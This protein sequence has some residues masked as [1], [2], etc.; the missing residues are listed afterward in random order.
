ML[1]QL[2]GAVAAA[3]AA[4]VAEWV[5]GMKAVGVQRVVSMLSES[6]L[7]TYAEPLPAAM[8]AAFGAGK[9]INVDAKAPGASAAGVCS[10]FS[11]C[12]QGRAS[13]TA[14]R[15]C[16]GAKPG[17]KTKRYQQLVVSVSCQTCPAWLLVVSR[18][19]A[20]GSAGTIALA[21]LPQAAVQSMSVLMLLLLLLLLLLLMLLLLL[22]L[23][24][25]QGPQQ[26][27]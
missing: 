26:R 27:S 6:E 12:F 4:A 7:A 3:A 2:S 24:L 23:L 17:A 25:H 21:A 14:V 15:S 10:H 16:S 1:L 5:D 18:S 11:V 22:L 20:E 13:A 9:Y 8:E 19:S